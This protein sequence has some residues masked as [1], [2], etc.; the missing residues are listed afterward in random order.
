M[1]TLPPPAYKQTDLHLQLFSASRTLVKNT[2]RQKEKEEKGKKKRK[3]KGVWEG[4]T[5]KCYSCRDGGRKDVGVKEVVYKEE[6]DKVSKAFPV[7]CLHF[8]SPVC[9]GHS[10]FSVLRIRAYQSDG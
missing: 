2:S 5:K 6:N 8:K 1:K 4:D 10:L 9:P 3:Q 7:L